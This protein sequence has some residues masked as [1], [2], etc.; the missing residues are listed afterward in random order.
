MGPYNLPSLYSNALH[1]RYFSDG[2]TYWL[3]ETEAP[4][5]YRPIADPVKVEVIP[6][7]VKNRDFYVK[8]DGATEKALKKLEFAA[9]IRQFFDGIFD[10]NTMALKA[11]AQEGAGN[12][13]VVN[14][15]GKKLPIAGSR[16]MI[17]I[18]AA[19]VAIMVCPLIRK[20]KDDR[21]E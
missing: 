21:M 13:T 2:G 7:F 11:D 16:G 12:L 8:G 4:A 18:M 3:K 1:G 14:K 20:R 10:E 6:T 9:Y 19:G 15:V 5:G 17:L